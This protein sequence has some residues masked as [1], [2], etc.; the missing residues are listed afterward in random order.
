MFKRREM[1]FNRNLIK[2][3]PRKITRILE[4]DAEQKL[5]MFELSALHSEGM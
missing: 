1:L 2:L 4:E 5:M 3:K